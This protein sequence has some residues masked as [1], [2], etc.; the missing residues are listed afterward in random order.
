METP[1]DGGKGRPDPGNYFNNNY[2]PDKVQINDYGKFGGSEPSVEND[3][4]P[5]E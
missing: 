1:G 5:G 4:Y 3:R 2:E